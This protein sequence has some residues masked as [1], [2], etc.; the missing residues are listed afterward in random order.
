MASVAAPHSWNPA[1]SSPQIHLLAA[2]SPARHKGEG[3]SVHTW[4]GRGEGK[5][6]LEGPWFIPALFEEAAPVLQTAYTG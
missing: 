5:A 2:E 6:P 3:S 1:G 4:G